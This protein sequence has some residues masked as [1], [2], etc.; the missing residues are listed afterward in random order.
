ME[1]IVKINPEKTDVKSAYL[2]LQENKETIVKE[3]ADSLARQT[4]FLMC[5]AT[6]GIHG[7][8]EDAPP[9]QPSHGVEEPTLTL[10]AKEAH[11]IARLLQGPLCGTP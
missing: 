6:M 2:A 11:C 1:I 4:E 3:F 9:G 5:M 8:K 7:K 10:T